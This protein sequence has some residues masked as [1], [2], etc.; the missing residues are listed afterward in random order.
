M[1]LLHPYAWAS[2]SD[3]RQA[4]TWEAL[5]RL[6]RDWTDRRHRI[7]HVPTGDD[8]RYEAAMRYLWGRDSLIVLEHDID[9]RPGAITALERCPH[10]LCAW[11]YPLWHRRDGW[12]WR[13]WADWWTTV[14]RQDHPVI[15]RL[16]RE[17]RENAALHGDAPEAPGPPYPTWA[18]RVIDDPA[19]PIGSQ[20]WIRDGE[21]WADLAALGLT[22]I[23]VG[24]QRA[25]PPNWTPGRWQTLD[26]RLAWYLWEQGY[27]PWH[28]HW[29][30]VRHRHREI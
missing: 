10:P 3:P 28:I 8:T 1:I 17:I 18:H 23:A 12:D 6:H 30:P 20:R 25:L 13:G 29:P 4:A 26:S 27:G 19:D 21:R 9:P 2:R 14:Q 7:W 5:R 24:V 22:K 16:D 15:T 11:A